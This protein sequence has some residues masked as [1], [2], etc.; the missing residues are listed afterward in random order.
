M[1]PELKVGDHRIVQEAEDL[2]V[3]TYGRSIS[4]EEMRALV[5]FE[6]ETSQG[7]PIFLMMDFT[8][9]TTISAETRKVVGDATKR[10]TFRAI[11]IFGAS[12]HMK[13]TAKLVNVAIA[14]F[15]SQPFPTEFFETREQTL[16][17]FDEIRRRG[18]EK[19]AS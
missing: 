12:F 16:A 14:L 9:L 1:D 8:R 17:W 2:F 15:R 19:S 3:I 4:P 6:A 13:V 18:L 5:D 7:K 10:V 11:G